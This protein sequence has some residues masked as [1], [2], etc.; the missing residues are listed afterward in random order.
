[1]YSEP[2]HFF[3]ELGKSALTFVT[4]NTCLAGLSFAN[5]IEHLI[6][7]FADYDQEG[8]FVRTLYNDM[9]WENSGHVEM[10]QSCK[11][12]STLH[13]SN[14]LGIHCGGF[15]V[16]YTAILLIPNDVFLLNRR[17]ISF[18]LEVEQVPKKGNGY[19]KSYCVWDEYRKLRELIGEPKYQECDCANPENCQQKVHRVEIKLFMRLIRV[20]ISKAVAELTQLSLCPLCVYTFIKEEETYCKKCIQK[21]HPH[22]ALCKVCAIPYGVLMKKSKVHKGCKNAYVK[23]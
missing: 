21:F 5:D 17:L 7:K 2:S 4:S 10:S 12:L 20:F 13:L 18:K 19:Y 16:T 23:K 14:A 6:M 15:L 1:M 11:T 9:S 8:L 22:G 3:S